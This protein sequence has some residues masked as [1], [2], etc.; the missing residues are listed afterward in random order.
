M[1][2]KLFQKVGKSNVAKKKKKRSRARKGNNDDNQSSYSVGTENTN[3]TENTEMANLKQQQSIWQ[4]I[5][6]D[7]GWTISKRQYNSQTPTLQKLGIPNFDSVHK[8]ADLKLKLGKANKTYVKLLKT[9]DKQKIE[10]VIKMGILKEVVGI[11]ER[12]EARRYAA[13]RPRGSDFASDGAINADYLAQSTR[14]GGGQSDFN[15]SSFSPSR[16]RSPLKEHSF[17]GTVNFKRSN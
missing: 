4:G 12:N 15:K 9:G 5:T 16:S 2:D 10:S 7:F 11:C 13:N 1:R 17:S 8:V 6:E 14:S 3:G